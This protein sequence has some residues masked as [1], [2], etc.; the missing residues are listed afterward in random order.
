MIYEED[1]SHF[2]E[3]HQHFAEMAN[4]NNFYQIASN[5]SCI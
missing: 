2:A 4:Q 1:G 5:V 3:L